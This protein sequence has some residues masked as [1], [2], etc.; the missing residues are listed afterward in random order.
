MKYDFRSSKILNVC[1]CYSKTFGTFR[2]FK[3]EKCFDLWTNGDVNV[4]DVNENT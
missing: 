4:E 2:S 3:N 1:F